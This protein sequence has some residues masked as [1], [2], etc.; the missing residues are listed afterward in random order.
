MGNLADAFRETLQRL[1]VY[2]EGCFC[3]LHPSVADGAVDL[4]TFELTRDA[5]AELRFGRAQ[6][7]GETKTGLQEAV[8]DAPQLADQ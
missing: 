8:I 2:F 5:L 7:I 4:A 6:L 1:R 3:A